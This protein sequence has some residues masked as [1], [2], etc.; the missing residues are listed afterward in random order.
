[1]SARQRHNKNSR[2]TKDDKVVRKW[3]RRVARQAA[4]LAMKR[5]E[6]ETIERERPS[7]G[8]ETW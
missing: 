3:L 8:W 4:R 2:F 1:M 6:P 5:H 7:R